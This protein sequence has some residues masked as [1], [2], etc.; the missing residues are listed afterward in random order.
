M[1]RSLKVAQKS[2]NKVMNGL[3]RRFP[4]Q[5][6]LAIE[7]GIS[8]STLNRFL[9]G[10][11]VDR[12]N[13]IEISENLNL[14]WQAIADLEEASTTTKNSLNLEPASFIT[15][16][17]ITEPRYFFGREK[18]LKR[19]F[20]LLKKHPLQ[21]AAIIGKRRTGKTSLLHYLKKIAN[22]PANQLRPSQK[23]DWLPHPENYSWVLVDFQDSRMTD[24]EKLLT[25]IL[26]SLKMTVPSPC[27]LDNFMEV[28]S[29]NL[30]SPT[31]IL[32]DEIGVGLE[33]GA[34]LDDRFWD[35][36]RSLA[37]NSTNGNLA[38]VL[39]SLRPPME[40]AKD[41]GRA[42]SFFNIFAQTT[43]LGPLTEAEA[44]ELIASSAIAFAEEDVEWILTESGRWQCLLQILCRECLFAMKN[45][46]TDGWREEGLRQISPFAPLLLTREK[47]G[48]GT[49]EVKNQLSPN[50]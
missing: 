49:G 20:N 3:K 48:E 30:N 1:S 38:F 50:C 23:N 11:P 35:S 34:E 21:S 46:E 47:E 7:L 15:G 16:N 44:R 22:R 19:L 33:R 32:M 40:I 5:S 12:L 41:T 9:H 28:V 25:Y 43:T 27:N 6:A 31:V 36:L 24:R 37:T 17:P 4:S 26:E 29:D 45:G 18:E 39:A 42:S 10:Q 13:F 2:I 8:R 14:D